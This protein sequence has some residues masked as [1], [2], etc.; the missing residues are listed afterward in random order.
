MSRWRQWRKARRDW[1][2]FTRLHETATKKLE[3]EIEKRDGQ[4][5][6]L[7]EQR[8]AWL[9]AKRQAHTEGSRTEAR[10]KPFWEIAFLLFGGC[11]LIL[12]LVMAVAYI[13]CDAG[14]SAVIESDLGRFAL[15]SGFA[16]GVI[17]VFA[18]YILKRWN[19]P[20]AAQ[21]YADRTVVWSDEQSRKFIENGKYEF[22]ENAPPKILETVKAN[23]KFA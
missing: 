10:R 9:A 3:A 2:K 12:S 17:S 18:Y 7:A 23:G 1:L 8:E 20:T 21:F 13:F 16:A 14:L 5:A 22:G 19:S 6:E 11:F 4:I 15:Y